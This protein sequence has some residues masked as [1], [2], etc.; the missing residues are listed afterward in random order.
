[1]EKNKVKHD[2]INNSIRLE[3]LNKLICEC[4]ENNEN[5]EQEHTG[6]LKKFLE[7]HLILLEKL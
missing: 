5:P 3:V 7:E 1:M 6:D 4:L 2:F